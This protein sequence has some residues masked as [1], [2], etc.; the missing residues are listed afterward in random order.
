MNP[1]HTPLRHQRPLFLSTY[2]PEKCGIATFTRDLSE[3]VSAHLV[4][5]SIGIAAVSR[6]PKAHSYP[7]EVVVKLN[8]ENRSG[9]MAVAE[10]INFSEYDALCVQHEFGI[11]GGNEGSHLLDLLRAARKPVV[12]TLHTV[13]AEPAAHYHER[14]RQVV[15]ASDAVV[16]LTPRAM[17]ILNDVYDVP[18]DKVRVI[19]HG[20]PDV[21]FVETAPY[22]RRFGAEGRTVLMTFGLIGP[23][24]GIEDMIDAM[25]AIV[26]RNPDVLYIVVG[27]THPGVIAHQG[28]VYREMLERRVEELGLQHNVSFVNRYLTSE[29]LNNYLKACDIYVTPY[30]NREQISSGTLAYATGMG[31]AVVSTPYYYAEDLLADGR[32]R[33][34]DFRSPESLSSTI[35]EL[36]AND[37]ERNAMRRRAYDFGRGM[38]WRAV[39]ADYLQLFQEVAIPRFPRLWS[40]DWKVLQH[41]K[42]NSL[43]V[44]QQQLVQVAAARTAYTRTLQGK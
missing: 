7:P 19:P 12:T 29:D 1:S 43:T 17:R 22:K 5:N 24:K 28:E 18:A 42:Q 44:A 21:P 14:L 8:K 15:D 33:L 16:V 6:D 41:A 34:A 25:P 23:S 11:F 36:I 40:F 3:A 27:A 4:E 13:L 9:Y 37:D 2:T 32:G 35:N 31:K 10:F 38:I 20:I 26:E 30:P 39:G